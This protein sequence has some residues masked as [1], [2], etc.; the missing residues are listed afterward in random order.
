VEITTQQVDGAVEVLVTG[1]LDASW[2][3]HLARALDEAVR[4]G[5]DHIRVN[6]AGVVYMSS[7]G[8]RVLLKFYKQLQ[9]INGSLAVSTP[10]EPVKTVLELAG[11]QVLLASTDAMR[12][13]APRRSRRF[14]TG[15]AA[16]EVFDVAPDASLTCRV[17]GQPE[18]LRSGAIGAE[19]CRRITCSADTIAVG[20]GAFGGDFD[21]CHTRFGDFLAVAGAAAYLPT[22]GTNVPDYLLATGA[23]VPQLSALYAL[24]CTGSF[25][26][27]ARFETKADKSEV[28]LT[29]LAAAALEI[30]ATDA[31]GIVLVAESAG[32][33]GATL[34]RSP[35]GAR[36]GADPFAYPEIR[37]WLSFTSERAYTRSIALVAGVAARTAD[38]SLGSLLRPLGPEQWPAGHFH[39]AA[40][41][42]QPLQKGDVQMQPVVS[43][44]FEGETLQGV[45][46]LLHDDRRITGAGESQFVRGACWV[47]PISEVMSSPSPT[48]R[49]LG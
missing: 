17:V 21:D 7:V 37:D 14:E 34:R 10:S 4:G 9:R 43:A 3:D 2:A 30:G 31:V 26:R 33:L 48:G 36:S 25:A 22:D 18:L 49:G 13:T 46:H 20:L 1:R 45:L 40:F 23:F 28:S 27:L 12:A 11:L 6:M 15:A 47:S 29:E 35:A 41:S 8:I 39:A 42:Y 44:L 5:A 24:V 32:L 19:H 16:F 38:A